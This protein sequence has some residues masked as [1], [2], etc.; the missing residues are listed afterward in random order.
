MG[1]PYFGRR[2]VGKAGNAHQTAH[3]LGHQ[4]EPAPVAVGAGGSETRNGTIDEAGFEP[5]E[6]FVTQPQPVHHAGP[7]VFHHDVGLLQ[8]PQK[9][10][11]SSFL[12]Q[13]QAEAALVPIQG[14]ET[15]RPFA[16]KGRP[17][18]AGVVPAVWF[19]NLDDVR[20]QVRQQHGANRSRH[21][22]GQVEND[23]PLQGK[24]VRFHFGNSDWFDWPE[25][26]LGLGAEPISG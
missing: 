23:Y 25:L 15:G 5:G 11:P 26:V 14:Q 8:Q 6:F 24:L 17:H 10:L 9:Y 3:T 7:E 1:T 2:A 4:V 20:P 12:P 18:L 16:R 21:Y 19:F 22:L 13:V